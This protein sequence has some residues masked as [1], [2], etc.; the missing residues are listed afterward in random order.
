MTVTQTLACRH[1]PALPNAFKQSSHFLAQ[2]LWWVIEDG[3]FNYFPPESLEY[4]FSLA[5]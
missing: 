5:V 1:K 2:R 3:H 4:F